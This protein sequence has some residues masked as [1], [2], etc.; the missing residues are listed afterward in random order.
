MKKIKEKYVCWPKFVCI[1]CVIPKA[2]G[3]VAHTSSS[4]MNINNETG[5]QHIL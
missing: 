5:E 1:V 3:S 2:E 4:G